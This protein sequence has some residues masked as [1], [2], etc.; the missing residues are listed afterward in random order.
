MLMLKSYI[1]YQNSFQE[2]KFAFD[3]GSQVIYID[4]PTVFPFDA[5]KNYSTYTSTEDDNLFWR[6]F[7]HKPI[8]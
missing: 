3:F 7:S 4:M 6:R 8:R 1:L 5:M 2:K